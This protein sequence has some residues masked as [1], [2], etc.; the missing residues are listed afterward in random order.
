MRDTIQFVL[1][2]IFPAV[3]GGS[4][5]GTF[6]FYAQKKRVET[7]N[8]DQAELRSDLDRIERRKND[9]QAQD[10]IVNNLMTSLSNA[11]VQLRALNAE[12]IEAAKVNRELSNRIADLQAELN[13]YRRQW[14]ILKGERWTRAECVKRVTPRVEAMPEEIE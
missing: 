4:V 7:A 8:A 11:M 5:V 12:V 2:Y 14:E 1:D 6:M 10:E 3:V 13:E 9:Y